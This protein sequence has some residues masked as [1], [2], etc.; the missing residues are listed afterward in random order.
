MVLRRTVVSQHKMRM[1]DDAADLLAAGVFGDSLGSLGHGVLG[2]L[3]GKEETDGSLDLPR[4]ESGASVVVGKAAGLGSNALKDVIDE[5]VHDAHGLGRDTG[6]GVH[7]LEN[8]VDVGGVRLLP[9]LAARAGG[10]LLSSLLRGFLAG[11][12]GH[13]VVWCVCF[14]LLLLLMMM[15]KER[16]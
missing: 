14:V 11:C 2:K 9:L 8:A 16:T 7:L 15:K 12:F 10:S 4:S 13:F 6:V 1:N 5:R 3:S